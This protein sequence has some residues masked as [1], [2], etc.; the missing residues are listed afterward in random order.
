MRSAGELSE[1]C[2]PVWGKDR[3]KATKQ[4]KEQQAVKAVKIQSK[5]VAKR[6][7]DAM[8][9]GAET[10]AGSSGAKTA[11]VEEAETATTATE[12]V[13]SGGSSIQA[14]KQAAAAMAAKL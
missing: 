11:R 7:V 8:Q 9:D 3:K 4:F 14:A 1:A 12:G 13:T 10:A 2:G 6:V 5:L